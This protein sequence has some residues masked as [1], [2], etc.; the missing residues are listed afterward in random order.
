MSDFVFPFSAI[1][2]QEDARTA[3]IL[4]LIDN[5]IGGVLLT[6]QKGTA[7]TSLVRAVSS[8]MHDI[9]LIELPL[10]ATE[11]RLT[12]SINIER[13][14]SGGEI[15]YEP[16][17]IANAKD[18]VLYVDE[19]N[20]LES[21]L[22]DILLDVSATGVLRVEREGVSHS[23]ENRF[24]LVGSMNP[25]EGELRPQFLDR[26][27]LCV[28]VFSVQNEWK[29]REII[30]RRLAFESD[31]E[32]FF[33][34]YKQEDYI[35]RQ[36]IL[37]ARQRLNSVILSDDLLDEAVRLAD[38][39]SVS[40]HRA[41]I[42]MVMAARALAAFLEHNVA[43]VSLLHIVAP[44]VLFHRIEG[45]LFDSPDKVL[46]RISSVI[47]GDSDSEA[48]EKKHTELVE[49]SDDMMVPG[50]AAAGSIVFD[51]LKKKILNK[52]KK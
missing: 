5:R 21:H 37:S 45:G 15:V 13:A 42:I 28:P 34:Q 32:S 30:K 9:P 26:F 17:L 51:F 12:G 44:W 39:A 38:A 16:G 14:L 4:G 24:L 10:N 46:R 8:V 19:V 36:Q 31:K 11:D 50:A 7:K 49:M 43:S 48:K 33:N 22:V 1:V 20:L 41:E 3:L 6:G 35:L 52:S 40:G 2:D 25:E 18:G 47:S 23:Q 29:R 27:G